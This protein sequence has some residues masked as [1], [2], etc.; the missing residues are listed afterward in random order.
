MGRYEKKLNLPLLPLQPRPKPSTS[1]SSSFSHYPTGA[2]PWAGAGVYPAGWGC[3]EDGSAPPASSHQHH[4]HRPA[5]LAAWALPPAW[6][7][8]RAATLSAGEPASLGRLRR[9]ALAGLV[10]AVAAL[11]LTISH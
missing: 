6:A 3:A 2:E 8:G 5:R 1:T 10:A 4:S 7:P 9:W 11:N